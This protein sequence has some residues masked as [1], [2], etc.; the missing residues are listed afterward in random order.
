[1]DTHVAPESRNTDNALAAG[2]NARRHACLKCQESVA[3]FPFS[4]A[5]QPIVDVA[6]V[7]HRRL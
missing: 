5:F 4:M 6:I 7:A 3:L 1:M 2:Q